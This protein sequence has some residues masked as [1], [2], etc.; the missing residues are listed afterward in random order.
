[1]VGRGI[2]QIE[3]VYCRCSIRVGFKIDN[4]DWQDALQQELY[5]FAPDI[6]IMDVFNKLHTKE[7]NSQQQMTEVMNAVENIRRAGKCS[8]LIVHHF[9]KS[10]GEGKSNRANQR[11]R[12]SSVLSGWSEN[13]L[14]LTGKVE[15]RIKVEHESKNAPEDPFL[16]ELEDVTEGDEKIGVRVKYVGDAGELNLAEKLNKILRAIEEAD[17]IGEMEF[18]T[19][20]GLHKATGIS[21]NTVRLYAK[22]L[23]EAK[24][25]RSE[26]I[27]LGD[28]GSLATCYYPLTSSAD[29]GV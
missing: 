9:R 2:A 21:E 7:E 18:R 12:G 26:K 25:I 13:S 6:V 15:K 10:G 27:K 20:N 22:T 24:K 4:P 1:M 23:E 3:D 17:R 8:V 5:T 29:Q 28:R 14:Y 16:F 19:A 11:M